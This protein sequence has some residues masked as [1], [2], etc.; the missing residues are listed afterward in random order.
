ML[1]PN[2]YFDDDDEAP[3]IA[4]QLRAVRDSPS[5]ATDL[6]NMYWNQG[7]VYFHET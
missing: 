7:S 6:Y 4:S 3:T 2:N 5:K 1:C